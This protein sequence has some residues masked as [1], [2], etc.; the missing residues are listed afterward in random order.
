MSVVNIQAWWPKCEVP[1]LWSKGKPEWGKTKESRHANDD[2]WLHNVVKA[3]I[4][5]LKAYTDVY[6]HKKWQ[7]IGWIERLR[8]PVALLLYT[9]L[10]A[11]F[12]LITILAVRSSVYSRSISRNDMQ[13]RLFL[14]VINQL[15]GHWGCTPRS[16]LLLIGQAMMH[17]YTHTPYIH[18]HYL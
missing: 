12:I 16:I 5:I 3:M 4:W 8:D 15:Q 10:I 1:E 18:I 11:D 7:V 2:A 17:T 9:C 14:C 6:I 13:E